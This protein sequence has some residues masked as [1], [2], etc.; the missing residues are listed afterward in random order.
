[1]MRARSSGNRALMYDAV[2]S[3]AAPLKPSLREAG[4]GDMQISK[5]LDWRGT[6][7]RENRRLAQDLADGIDPYPG[8]NTKDPMFL[9]EALNSKIQLYDPRVIRD[10]RR[11][12]SG[13]SKFHPATKAIG[14]TIA[15]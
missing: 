3:A 13:W 10:V 1:W 11:D 8:W 5:V 4:W 6:F 14:D 2:D 9:S 7:G 15:V 12:T